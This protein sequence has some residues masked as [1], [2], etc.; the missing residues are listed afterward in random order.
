MSIL[1]QT[2]KRVGDR[3]ETGLLWT[4]DEVA[5]PNAYNMA[6]R[7]LECLERKMNRNKKLKD[8][9]HRQI[10]E[11]VSKKYIHKATDD[12]LEQADTNRVWY[13]PLGAVINPKKPEKIR[14][15]WD[16]A[17][18]VSGVSLNKN[19]LKGPDLL[20][21][22]PGILF[23]FRL[24]RVAVSSDIQ[25]MFHQIQ[26]R[27]ED[28]NAQRFLWRSDPSK[29]PDIYLMDVATFGSTCSPAS[30][31]F[32]KNLNAE[33]HSTKYPDA[34]KSIISRYYVDDYF[35]SFD[36]E[37]EAR[38]IVADIRTIQENA[39]FTLHNW[40]SN[41]IGVLNHIQ[42]LP[43]STTQELKFENDE[44]LE[45]VLG[46]LWNPST[47]ELGF[48]THMSDDVKDLLQSGNRPTKRQILRCVM[49]LFDPLGLLAPFLIHGKVLIQDLWRSG[50]SWDEEVGDLLFTRWSEWIK[51]IEHIESV[52]I[53]RCYFAE[54][55]KLT[56]TNTELHIFVDAS[57]V[58][59]SCVAYIRIVRAD[60]SVD[61][62]LVSG[63]SKVAPLK[64]MSIPRLELQSCFLGAQLMSFIKNNHDI[65]I[66]R[67]VLWTDSRTA[68]SWIHSDPR[69]YRPFVAHRVGEI[70]E[71]T[72]PAN[73]RWVPSKSNPADEATKWGKGPYFTNNSCWF[74]G[75]DFLRLPEP[76]WPAPI[77]RILT[78]EE[79]LRASVFLHAEY[80]PVIV[81]ERFSRWER[82]YRA[83]AY[84]L[85]F[86][87]YYPKHIDK[88]SDPLEQSDLATAI[89][90]I[91]KQVQLETFPQ[92][93][94]TLKQNSKETLN[95]GST[96]RK[97]APFLAEDGLLRENSRIRNS[98]SVAF[99]TRFPIIL[100]TKH[101]VTFLVVDWYH[102]HYKHANFETVVNEVRQ[103]YTIPG[104]RSLAKRV[105]RGCQMCRLRNAKPAP[106][107]IAPL[108][109]CRL[110]DRQRPFT[111]TGLDYFG[112]LLV[113]VGR[114]RVKRWIALF[115]CLTTRAIHLEVVYSLSAASCIFAVRRFVSRRGAP[116]EF[117]SDNG[118]NFVGA[119]N[120]LR[121]QIRL[122][123]INT[124]TNCS[125][126]WHFNPPGAPHMGG[127]W[128]R[129]VRSV[130]VALNDGYSEGKLND[131]G[132]ITL[133]VEAE[134][135][136]NSR[137]LT[138]LPL[139]S[140]EF[141]ALTPNHFLLGSSN[142]VKQPPVPIE[143]RR[144][145][146]DS[147]DLIQHE[148]NIFWDRWV[149]EYLPV[150]RRQTKWFAPT[151]QVEVG[152]LVLVIDSK[153]R[154]GWIRGK[155]RETIVAPDG[156]VRRVV[157]DTANG[158]IRR[159]V[160]YLALLDV[161]ND[162]VVSVSTEIHPGEDV[163]AAGNP[164]A[165]PIDD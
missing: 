64:P 146:R 40:R 148:L 12:E 93:L 26:I 35:E 145:L 147:W 158:P 25:Q 43:N 38:R 120:I 129:L 27:P 67:T 133:I 7:R 16:A 151:R 128:E 48:S 152:D 134:G 126:K 97:Y 11:Y 1:K 57:E 46:M 71:H 70:L 31:Q 61:L 111:F 162:S 55:T 90:Q 49:S 122:K 96:I 59:Y 47:D 42:V 82:L 125:T 132:L 76:D 81:Y 56:Y 99:G 14:I 69:N 154:N 39:G 110:A 118:T 165:A 87:K 79:E 92:E 65:L 66:S 83:I 161:S 138:Y 137:P 8:N 135:I 112:P 95:S 164:V 131:E 22:L 115:T 4:H 53:S 33:Q 9:L 109:P 75:P 85:R 36:D 102:R 28:R 153:T 5:L 58:A 113:I 45:R 10:A 98:K 119:S 124:F 21:S 156:N 18:E 24:F 78:T 15:I 89:Q 84:V 62:S 159:A 140:E 139:D 41:S 63:K 23:Q 74:I 2:T 117:Y 157:V 30:A 108:P 155:V 141:E 86:L 3:F 80:K 72:T 101:R 107:P 149:K 32:V 52:R 104:L 106:P 50:I 143:E 127:V 29:T 136:V 142:G 94:T 91:L 73:W 6:L 37:N 163:N 17:A 51:M 13:L 105:S 150:I 68:L 54:A 34:A 114:S 60:G 100:P 19:L 77:D 103:L 144:S 121:E 20:S 130:K 88:L 160:H 44:K 116:A 123:M